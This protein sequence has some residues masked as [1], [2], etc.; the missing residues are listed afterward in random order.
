MPAEGATRASGGTSGAS[1][2]GEAPQVSPAEGA[3]RA[4]GGTSEASFEGE[5]PQAYACGGGDAS[6]NNCC[7]SEAEKKFSLQQAA[8]SPQGEASIAG[9]EYYG[10]MDNQEGSSPDSI[11]PI[12]TRNFSLAFLG[13]F[14]FLFAYFALVPT[15]PIY[16]AHLGSSEGEI[17]ILVGIYSVASLVSRLFAGSAL[18]RYSEKRVMVVAALL[19][20]VSFVAYITLRPFWPFLVVRLFQGIAYAFFDTAV[21]AM[22]V[23][24]VP[25]PYRGRA[26][27][28]F[29]LASAIG[30]VLAPSF[31]MFL[32]NLS[33][34]A[35]LFLV[36]MGLSLCAS[37]SSAVL[38]GQEI[39]A[40]D[41]AA[42][43]RST[44]LVETKIIVPALSAFFFYF[45]LGTVMAFFSLYGMQRGMKNPGY[46][47]SAAALMTIAG[48]FAGAKVVDAWSKEKTIMTFTLTS[49]VA[50]VLLSFS[51]T[52]PM[53]IFVGLLW[54]T[55]VAFIFPVTIAYAFEYA[56]SSGG[57]A[58]GTFRVLTDLGQAAGPMVMGLI[59][60]LAGYPAMFLCLAAI[61]FVNLCYFQFFVRKKRRMAP[62]QG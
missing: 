49:M 17:G 61:C 53:F 50:M 6:P 2:E 60:P 13:C 46:F 23:K 30:T 42:G 16:L 39:M 57:T 62:G 21:F 41:R 52:L 58:V 11:R 20:A 28:Y 31:G 19:F 32:V 12:L 59:I 54:G 27:S 7:R 45:V 14:A 44:F 43:G 48:R 55:G 36:C 8:W 38:R 35:V 18:L 37:L 3:T 10:A 34:F 29:M 22:I 1:F 33:G 24:I 40:P 5:A 51:R 25:L 9:V 56:G 47:F 4:S 15:L 26:L